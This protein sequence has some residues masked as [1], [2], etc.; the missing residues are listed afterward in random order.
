MTHK[1]IDYDAMVCESAIATFEQC[2]SWPLVLKLLEAVHESFLE[3]STST[4][5]AAVRACQRNSQWTTALL[6]FGV[7]TRARVSPNVDAHAAA[8]HA[9]EVGS[10]S[11][12]VHGVKKKHHKLSE[13]L[14][15]TKIEMAP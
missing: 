15:D 4:C 8:I 2:R 12:E 7:M 3:Y 6:A 5:A 13:K 14:R 9:C 10:A 11:L 1:R